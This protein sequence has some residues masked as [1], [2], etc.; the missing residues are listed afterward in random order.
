MRAW[1]CRTAGIYITALLAGP[2]L[3]A[4]TATAPTGA[5]TVGSGTWTIQESLDATLPGGQIESVSC[6]T[7]TA[8]TA[9]GSYSTTSGT[10]VTLAEAWNGTSWTKQ[11]TPNP[12]G[13]NSPTLLGVSCTAANFCEAVGGYSTGSPSTGVMLAEVWHGRSWQ[14]QP[15]PSPAGAT[16]AGLRSVSCVSATFCE[17]VGFNSTS[18][19]AR[20]PLAEVWNGASWRPQ[21]TPGPAGSTL[22]ELSGVSCVSAHFCEAVVN[23]PDSA[24]AAEQWNGRSWQLQALPPSVGVGTVS[25]VSA[26]FCEAVG[27]SAGAAI[28]NGTSWSAQPFPNPTGGFINSFGSVSCASATF[29]EWVSSSSNGTGTVV[30][31]AEVWNGTSW[32][33]QSTPGPPGAAFAGLN[34]VSC[35]AANACEA[36]GDF[37]P[38]LQGGDLQ[39]LA[40]AWN[41]SSWTAQR[42]VRPHSAARNSLSAVSC[43]SAGFCEAVGFHM[44]ASG[45]FVNLA[46]VWNGTSWKIQTTPDPAQAASGAR[47]AMSGVA[48]VSANFCEAVGFSAVA[49]GAGAW[50]WNGKSWTAQAIPGS[51]GLASVSCPSA[52]FCEAV[53]GAPFG[54]AEVDMWN[55]TSWSAQSSAP[56]YTFLNSVSCASA[57]FCEATGFGPPGDNAEVW[58]GSSWSAQPTPT[59]PGGNSLGLT[60]VSCPTASSCEAAGTYNLQSTGAAVTL[61]EVWNGTAWTVQPTPNPTASLGSSLSGVWCTSANSCTAVGNYATTATGRTVAL[62]W[63]GASWRL[64]ATPNPG[65]M[66]NNMFNG[67]SCGTSSICTA[68]GSTQPGLLQGTLVERRG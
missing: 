24:P 35:T 66:A 40:A 14:L 5:G 47:A 31:L 36:G 34:G 21:P 49:P 42:P 7:A 13:G 53:G 43:V 1:T 50:V 30:T 41:G 27:S 3:T 54:N 60:A 20:V 63:N 57:N 64:Q 23:S 33:V 29:C 25:C 6:V 55:G 8:C 22:A 65:G 26:S 62:A 17:A 19:A 58:N 61:A 52:S 28:W 44:D 68:V 2:A 18:S 59:P 32:S 9:V 45:N 37:E 11:R 48:C 12:V 15:V 4:V 51:V 16:S 39:A 67:V 10:T 56:G 46:E 38:T